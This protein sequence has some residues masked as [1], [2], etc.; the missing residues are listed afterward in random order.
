MNETAHCIIPIYN[1]HIIYVAT[2]N[3]C[4]MHVIIYIYPYI[5]LYH[6]N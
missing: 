2:Y 4:I 3:V 1:L 6:D 5:L